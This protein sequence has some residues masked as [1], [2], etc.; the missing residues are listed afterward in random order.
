MG[1]SREELGIRCRLQIIP[2]LLVDAVL[3]VARQGGLGQLP[4][5]D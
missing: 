5:L 4:D 1:M 2:V 3:G